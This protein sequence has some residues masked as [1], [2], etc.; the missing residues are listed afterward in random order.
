MPNF[1]VTLNDYHITSRRIHNPRKNRWDAACN[2]RIDQI[3]PSPLLNVG[4]NWYIKVDAKITPESNIEPGV[5]GENSWCHNI[6]DGD[7]S[8][9]LTHTPHWNYTN[10]TSL[11]SRIL[12]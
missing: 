8:F 12:I 6:I 7:C 4:K 10:T 5:Q 9:K 1:S 11:V 2:L 3:P